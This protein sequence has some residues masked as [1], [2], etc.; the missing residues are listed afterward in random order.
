[1]TPEEFE[2]I[3]NARLEKLFD[4]YPIEDLQPSVVSEEMKGSLSK[5]YADRGLRTY[6]ENVLKIALK[7]MAIAPDQIQI[8]YYKSR[9]DF[10][11]Q[12]LAKGKQMYNNIQPVKGV[13]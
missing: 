9:V 13:K 8:A 10:A 3:M 2:K 4:L 12:L 6:I 5:F 1:M 7:N 11:E